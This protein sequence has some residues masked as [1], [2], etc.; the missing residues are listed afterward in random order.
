MSEGICKHDGCTG[1]I[2]DG[3]EGD[4]MPDTLTWKECDECGQLYEFDRTVG[5]LRA[6]HV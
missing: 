6:E 1:E 4:D 2:T 5:A 3:P